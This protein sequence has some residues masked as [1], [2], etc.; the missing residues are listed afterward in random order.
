MN[1]SP[2]SRTKDWISMQ[3]GH[4]I[5]IPMPEG[6]LRGGIKK[7]QHAGRCDEL[8]EKQHPGRCDELK[9]KQH[10]GSW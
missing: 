6:Q 5:A 10:A 8:K 7:M 9:E 3:I 2:S 1:T 4:C